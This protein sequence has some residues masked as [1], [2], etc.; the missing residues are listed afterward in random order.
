MHF[1]TL[2]YTPH[3]IETCHWHAP[4]EFLAHV[5]EAGL[6]SGRWFVAECETAKMSLSG[7]GEGG[8]NLPGGSGV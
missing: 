2:T 5:Q 4:A 7:E 3:F 8:G 6:R 1:G